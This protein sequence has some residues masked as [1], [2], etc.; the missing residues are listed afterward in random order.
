[1]AMKL[2]ASEKQLDNTLRSINK[3]LSDV[4]KTFGGESYEYEKAQAVV[5]SKLKGSVFRMPEYNSSG[6]MVKP[7]QIGRSRASLDTLKNQTNEVNEIRQFEKDVEKSSKVQAQ[8]YI[9]RLIKEGIKPTQQNIRGFA[10]SIHESSFNDIYKEV[11]NNP[12]IPDYEKIIFKNKSST[13]HVNGLEQAE[14]YGQE[15]LVRYDT[16]Y[17]DSLGDEP[18][19]AEG[20]ESF[21]INQLP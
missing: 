1:M 6:E 2:T 18:D 10:T 20:A 3:H 7:L 4:F 14:Q 19:Y 21:N 9:E 5:K 8:K 12:N 13:I 17:F 11:M 15:L 16:V